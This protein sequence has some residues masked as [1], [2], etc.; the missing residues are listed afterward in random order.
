MK[1][2]SL[3][4]KQTVLFAKKVIKEICRRRTSTGAT[5]VGLYGNLGA[6]KTALT[7]AVAKEL[8][9]KETVLSPTFVLERIYKLPKK[10]GHHFTHLIHIDAYRFEDAKELLHLGW[11]EIIADPHNLIFIEWP[12]QVAGIMPKGH[13]QIQFKHK[14][15]NT[16]EIEVK[17][18]L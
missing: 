4:E 16:R 2:V 14:G 5:V 8:G 18:L 1:I 12:E 15:E 13:I 6:G 17:G 3:N 10:P 7:K 9:I 11:E